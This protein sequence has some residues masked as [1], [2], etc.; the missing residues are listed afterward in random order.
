MCTIMK[1]LNNSWGILKCLK[2]AEKKDICF[3]IIFIV[4]IYSSSINIQ[5]IHCQKI[6]NLFVWAL[7]RGRT[8]WTVSISSLMIPQHICSMCIKIKTNQVGKQE[9]GIWWVQK[10]FPQYGIPK[11]NT[12][13]TRTLSKPKTC[14]IQTDFTILSTIK[15]A[16][17]RQ[18]LQ[19]YLQ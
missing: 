12:C 6:Y 17:A 18:T 4:E 16:Q 13:L 15:P 10:R 14:L 19:S 7:E 11:P 1:L 5:Y 8:R 3:N 9:V 2:S